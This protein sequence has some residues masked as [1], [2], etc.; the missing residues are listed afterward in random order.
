MA[1]ALPLGAKRL[2]SVRLEPFGVLDQRPEL[3]E[4]RLDGS[5][6]V[7]ELVVP[8]PG[9]RELSPGESQL[10]ATTLL[11]VAGER[12][13]QVELVRGTS[14]SA[15]LELAGHRD[16]RSPASARSSRGALRPQA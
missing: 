1:Q 6:T 2:L 14:E 9:R 5:R 3:G 8:A 12:V 11:F 13:E 7:L 4:T 10:R 15:L 16:Q